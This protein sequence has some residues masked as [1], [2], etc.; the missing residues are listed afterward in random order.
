MDTLLLQEIQRA[1]VDKDSDLG[2]ILRKCKVLA[3]GLGSNPLEEWLIH[4]A[5]GYP[6]DTELPKYRI[7]PLV[8]KGNFSDGIRRISNATVLLSQIPAEL[9]QKYSHYQFRGSVATAEQMLKSFDDPMTISVGLL[10]GVLTNR[11]FQ[12][13]QC[14]EAWGEISTLNVSTM[15][16][17]VR[18]RLL[19]F[20]LALGKAYPS[21]SQNT[22]IGP[23][24]VTQIFNTTVMGSV[25]VVG[26]ATNSTINVIAND[27]NSLAA[28]LEK[29]GIDKG[30]IQELHSAIQAEPT[31]ADPNGGPLV[32]K[33]VG[34]MMAKAAD[35]T[36]QIGL[37]AAGNLLAQAIAMF[38]GLAT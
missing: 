30:D 24:Q 28:F 37:G 10:A 7:W 27:W 35:G 25:G 36:W 16:D 15:L 11:V 13:H 33:W 22:S 38:Y 6:A 9:R 29:Q 3:A 2:T 26:T 20:S 17:S 32:R 8:V 34:K 31:N 1:C 21:N 19:D 12:H 4:E 18:N 5:G 23:Q 14:W